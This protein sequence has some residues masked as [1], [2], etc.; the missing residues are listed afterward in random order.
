MQ[1][2]RWSIEKPPA[3][4]GELI[5]GLG[6][7]NIELWEEGQPVSLVTSICS[8]VGDT[9]RY[10]WSVVNLGVLSA[11]RKQYHYRMSDGGLNSVEGD[12]VLYSREHDDGVMPRPDE[13]D[14]YIRPI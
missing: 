3:I 13:L 5:P 7:V 11:T 6:S 10:S 8:E 12:F 1:E 4:I 9:G 14:T 2:H